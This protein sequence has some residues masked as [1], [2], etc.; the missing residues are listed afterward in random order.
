MTVV[1]LFPERTNLLHDIKIVS[2][3]SDDNENDQPLTSEQQLEDALSR[4]PRNLPPTTPRV[5]T[6]EE[7]EKRENEAVVCFLQKSKELPAQ[8]STQSITCYGC[9]VA[10][11]S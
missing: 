3:V 7:L 4:L 11:L 9:D 6:P 10:V 5:L 8:N 2:G 1:S